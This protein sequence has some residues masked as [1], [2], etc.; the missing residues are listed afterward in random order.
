MIKQLIAPLAGAFAFGKLFGDY[1]READ[2]LGEMAGMLGETV[3]DIDA[4]SQA[5]GVLG[6]SAE[7]L[8][9]SLQNLTNGLGV[10]AGAGAGRAKIALDA[11]GIS[12]K[13]ASGQARKAT[14]VLMD[15][16]DKAKSMN[17]TEFIGLAAKLG[18]DPGTIRML[19]TGKTSVAEMVAQMKALAYTQEDAD[20]A[21]EFNDN[22]QLLGKSPQALASI[23]FRV[24]IPPLSFFA[25][26]LRKLFAYLSQHQA[27]VLAFFSILAAIITAKLV[28]AIW[29]M[30]AAWLAN[31]I[32]WI[33]VK[34]AALALVL[35]DLW[36]FINGGSV[37][38]G[39]FLEKLG[40]GKDSIDKL[41]SA[42]KQ[43]IETIKNYGPALTAMAVAIKI[44]T[45]AIKLMGLAALSNPVLMIIGA[46]VAGAALIYQNW[47][48]ISAWFSKIFDSIYN[49][50][51]EWIDAV[52]GI[53]PDWLKS[54]LGIGGGKLEMNAQI[55]GAAPVYDAQADP[56]GLGIGAYPM[57]PGAM[58]SQTATVNNDSQINV[59]KVEV[60]TQATDAQGIARD[61]GAA[62]NNQLPRNLVANAATPVR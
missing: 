4:W 35:E 36:V 53:L 23:I 43:L 59:N 48:S 62:M 11:L 37:A 18:L 44:V 13:D 58:A 14:E 55:N 5:A 2:A 52:I 21:N 6:G 20:I 61:M 3:E 10:V 49:T 30:T 47:D 32:T 1:T 27:A 29:K 9:S 39:L 24:V 57:P 8:R 16:A 26:N 22:I 12:V 45:T 25:E 7:G 34:V 15:L 31:P 60:V 40:F 50:I 54:L 38:L 17:R 46:L 19:Q 33:I 51:S 56:L 42:G 41:R 28:P